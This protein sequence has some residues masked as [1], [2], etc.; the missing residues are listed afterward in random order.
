MA[1]PQ[2][3]IL[4]G[5]PNA[6]KGTQSHFLKQLLSDRYHLDFGSELRNFVAKNVGDIKLDEMVINPD[7]KPEDVEVA[8]RLKTDMKASNPAQSEDLKYV[9]E[10]A[11][12]GCIAR[13]Q[14]MIVEG[15]GRLVEEA[16]WL[17]GFMASKNVDVCIF[18]LYVSLEEVLKRASSRYYLPGVTQPFM[19]LEDATEYGTKDQLVPFRR[20]EDEDVEGT[21]KRYRTMYSDN[22][23]KIISIYQ[24]IAKC[25]VYTL[26]GHQ[27]P[28]KV[29]AD[30][31]K[32]FKVFNDTEI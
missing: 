24:L 8:K 15:P 2:I 31:R 5:P 21:K 4:Y 18:H 23:A 10:S 19:S 7:S 9:I 12:H 28:E 27:E 6:G 22:F 14:G 11:I 13:G 32:Y 3:I 26:D 1:L 25:A 20:T 29:S 16:K 17:S 30:I